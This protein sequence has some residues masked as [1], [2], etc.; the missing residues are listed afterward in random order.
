MIAHD[1]TIFSSWCILQEQINLS[2]LAILRCTI[3]KREHRKTVLWWRDDGLKKTKTINIGSHCSFEVD[4]V[5][6]HTA[7]VCMTIACT[8][9]A[10]VIEDKGCRH[11]L[12]FYAPSLNY[13]QMVNTWN[14]L[15]LKRPF[16]LRDFYLGIS[17]TWPDII[18]LM[19]VW[20]M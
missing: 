11:L 7:S 20:P 6:V 5:I 18:F 8:T 15:N 2:E 16:K 3:L 4:T 9:A 10:F 14:I 19:L 1:K 12:C 13:L 17:T